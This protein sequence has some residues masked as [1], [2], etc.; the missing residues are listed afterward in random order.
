[1]RA[2]G[3]NNRIFF[4]WILSTIVRLRYFKILFI[5]ICNIILFFIGIEIVIWI[6][7]MRTVLNEFFFIFVFLIVGERE[8]FISR[9][10]DLVFRFVQNSGNLVFGFSQIWK[11]NFTFFIQKSR[12]NFVRSNHSM[13]HLFLL[14]FI[15]GLLFERIF[16]FLFVY[17]R[18]SLYLRIH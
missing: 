9:F 8:N 13:N 11:L 17:L 5:I 18:I 2:R 3:Y 7:F 1:M 10:N 6:F 14:R 12:L 4:I 16:Q 15:F